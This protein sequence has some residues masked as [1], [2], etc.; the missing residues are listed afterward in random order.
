MKIETLG[1]RRLGVPVRQLTAPTSDV[2]AGFNP[3]M[4]ALSAS[5]RQRSGLYCTTIWRAV[6]E[7]IGAALGIH[8][9][10]RIVGAMR[11]RLLFGLEGD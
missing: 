7:K 4:P 9:D 6:L 3:S 10:D 11:L 8:R 2:E 5:P 1:S